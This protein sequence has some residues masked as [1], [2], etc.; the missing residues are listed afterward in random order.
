MPT[1]R[2]HSTGA[3]GGLGPR[4]R[5]SVVGFELG[6]VWAGTKWPEQ[7]KRVRLR[8]HRRVRVTGRMIADTWAS[9]ED[10]S[11]PGCAIHKQKEGAANC[12]PTTTSDYFLAVA[13][14]SFKPGATTGFRNGI[15]A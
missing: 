10:S 14:D 3:S 4:R 15:I 9:L 12:A 13:A 6:R 7:A 8:R 1:K 11:G 5:N 2:F